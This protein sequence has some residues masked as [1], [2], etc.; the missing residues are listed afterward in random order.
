[1]ETVKRTETVRGKTVITFE[2]G[3]QVWLAPGQE[4]DFPLTEGAEVDRKEFEQFILLRQYPAALEKAVAMLALRSCTRAE[5]ERKLTFHHYDPCVIE[6]VLFKLEKEGLLN[7]SEF[8]GQWIQARIK[9]YGASRIYQ[10]LVRKGID[11]DEAREAL[12]SC[13]E[14]EQT[15][16]AVYLAKKKLR[17][18]KADKDR[19]VLFRSITGMLVRR[20][21]SWEIAKKAFGKAAEELTDNE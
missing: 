11:R 12:A 4:P 17:S 5:T 15:E 3:W 16:H 1:M 10:E 6:M 19:Q 8:T 9:K 14:E 13:S 20:G 18:I 7:D 2:S 21:Y